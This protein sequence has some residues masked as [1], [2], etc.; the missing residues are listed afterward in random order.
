MKKLL[1]AILALST[2]S[3][4]AQKH[5]VRFTDFNGSTGFDSFN[6]DFSATKGAENTKDAESSKNNFNINYAYAVTSDIQVGVAYKN[7]TMTSGDAVTIGLSGYY[8]LEGKVNDTCYVAFHYDMKTEANDD[9]STTMGLEYGH[10][11]ALGSWK[12]L[13]LAYSPSIN[14]SQTTSTQDEDSGATYEDEVTSALAWNFVKF[15]V[16]F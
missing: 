3:A 12:G 1:V 2:V 14:L 10:R 9:A 5:M 6:V 13:N 16:L 8:N 15:D 4:F 11:F 7:E